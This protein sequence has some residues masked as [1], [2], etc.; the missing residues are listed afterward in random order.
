V[1]VRLGEGYMRNYFSWTIASVISLAGI[2]AASAADM[3]V[4]ARPVPVVLPYNWTGC[5]IGGNVGGKWANSTMTYSFRLR[6]PAR[7]S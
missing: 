3:A 1:I 6:L 2:G 5:Y 7:E 4:K